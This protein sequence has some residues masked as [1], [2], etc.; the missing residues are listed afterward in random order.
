MI[1]CRTIIEIYLTNCNGYLHFFNYLIFLGSRFVMHVTGL[2]EG[3]WKPSVKTLRS[4]LRHFHF[5][6]SEFYV[7]VLSYNQT[8]SYMKITTNKSKCTTY[9]FFMK[10]KVKIFLTEGLNKRLLSF[11]VIGLV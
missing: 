9:N 6:L 8:G 7:Y 2:G 5:T 3:T 4:P 10:L 11:M 1:D